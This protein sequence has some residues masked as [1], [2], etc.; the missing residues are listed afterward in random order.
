MN[1]LSPRLSR[2][3]MEACEKANHV[4]QDAVRKA[5]FDELERLQPVAERWEDFPLEQMLEAFVAGFCY[6]MIHQ[7]SLT[8]ECE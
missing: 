5:M 8:R 6:G 7:Y 3:V 2:L 1:S 4:Y